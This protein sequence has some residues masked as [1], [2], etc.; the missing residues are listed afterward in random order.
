MTPEI[1]WAWLANPGASIVA[2]CLA[3]AVLLV[4][5]RHRN[6]EGK[7]L[8]PRM[9]SVFLFGLA[10]YTMLIIIVGHFFGRTPV[11]ATVKLFGDDRIAWIF[12]G[13]VMDQF[14]RIYRAFDP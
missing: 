2:G 9:V 1:V 5:R 6:A 12:V 7:T 8:V 14:A 4:A 13:L 11:S 10:G 3:L